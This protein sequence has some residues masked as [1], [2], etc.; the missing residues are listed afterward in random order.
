MAE[1]IVNVHVDG[2]HYI[3]FADASAVLEPCGAREFLFGKAVGSTALMALAAADAARNPAPELP[4]EINLFYRLL[5][6]AA[7]PEMAAYGVRPV[8]KP[9]IY[10]PSCGLFIAR[11]ERFVAGGQGRRQRRRP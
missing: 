4:D 3:N 9:D 8:A 10:Y 11:D 1:Y 6:L 2:A 7:A 5:A